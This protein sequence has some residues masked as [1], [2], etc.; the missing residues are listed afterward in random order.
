MKKICWDIKEAEPNYSIQSSAT[1]LQCYWCNVQNKL[2]ASNFHTSSEACWMESSA[3]S[4]QY[5][6]GD[7]SRTGKMWPWVPWTVWTVFSCGSFVSLIKI[8]KRKRGEKKRITMQTLKS[9]Q[10]EMVSFIWHKYSVVAALF[11]CFQDCTFKNAC[12]TEIHSEHNY[13]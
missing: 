8:W 10:N 7:F 2:T 6:R 3:V 13:C 12:L 5:W 1:W 4:L 11:H 9:M